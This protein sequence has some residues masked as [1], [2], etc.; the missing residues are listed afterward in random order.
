M[1]VASLD[2][3]GFVSCHTFPGR[4][5]TTTEVARLCQTPTQPKKRVQFQPV[6]GSSLLPTKEVERK[7]IRMLEES[8][9]GSSAKSQPVLES[10]QYF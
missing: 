3:N 7:A 4:K 2:E 5:A 8:I 10:I 9:M 6:S 1:M